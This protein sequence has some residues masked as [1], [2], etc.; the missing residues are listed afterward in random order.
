MI[1]YADLGLDL[2]LNEIVMAGS[3][4]AAITSGPDNAQ[5]QSKDILGQA[6]A[7]VRFFDIRIAAQT[8]SGAGGAKQAQLTAFHAP[9]LTTETKTRF[10]SDLG[11]NVSIERSKLKGDSSG[12]AWGLGLTKILQDAKAFVESGV[13][14][15]E[16]LILKFD[17]CTNWDLIAETCRTVLGTAIY[18]GGGN[19]NTKTLGDLSGKVVCAFMTPGYSSLKLPGQKVGI[20][21]IKNLYKPPAGYESDFDGLQYWGA[22]G[23]QINNSGFE[24]K[25]QENIATQTKI[26]KSASTGVGDKKTT[27]TRKV[28]TPGCSAADPNAI[29]MMYWTTTGVFKSIKARNEMMW[30]DNHVAGLKSIWKSGFEEYIKNALPDNVDAMSF[31]SGGTLK[32]FMP[33]IVMIDFAAMDK[34]EHIHKL[35]TLAATKL[36]KI[37]QKLDIHGGRNSG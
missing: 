7:G 21:H 1:K 26:M 25:I 29:G 24:G 34:C 4:D 14:D 8:I 10:S 3:H 17:K 35:N 2:Q 27:F 28:K 19:L 22:G 13:Y 30:D 37:C 5:T 9:G 20:T 33:N 6:I 18:T 12:A 15:T 23:T 32:L 36:V 16:F 31:S 11:R